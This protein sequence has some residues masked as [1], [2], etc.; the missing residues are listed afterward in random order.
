MHFAKIII[1]VL[2]SILT[3]LSYIFLQYFFHN[4]IL[5]TLAFILVSI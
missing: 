3:R 1:Y 4:K 2:F 5:F